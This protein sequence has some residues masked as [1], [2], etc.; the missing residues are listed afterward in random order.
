MGWSLLPK[1]L[2]NFKIYCAPPNLG[3][4][5]WICWI[6]FA[7]RPIFSGL[8]F[9]NEPEISDSGPSALKSLPDDLCSGFYRPEKIHRPQPGLNPRTLDLEASTL[10][11]GRHPQYIVMCRYVWCNALKN[12]QWKLAELKK[13]WVEKLKW[14][15]LSFSINK[16]KREMKSAFS[17]FAT[18]KRP[19]DYHAANPNSLI[20]SYLIRSLIWP[21]K[22]IRQW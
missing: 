1:G 19:C 16:W 9:F 20:W 5:T 10:P 8:R 4:R 15:F 11:R 3:I 6:N 2:R 17:C 13:V 7:Q 14:N 18:D 21:S 22:A 12:I